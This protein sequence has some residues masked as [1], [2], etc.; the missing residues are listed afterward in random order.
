MRVHHQSHRLGTTVPS[1]VA[2]RREGHARPHA[3]RSNGGRA[4][5]RDD[6]RITLG[7]LRGCGRN[8]S[9]ITDS[10]YI[11]LYE[12]YEPVRGADSKIDTVVIITLVFFFVFI[13]IVNLLY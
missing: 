11:Y 8:I 1:A 7:K 9:E 10:D 2:E 5:R 12:G 4:Q 6:H 13:M 3:E